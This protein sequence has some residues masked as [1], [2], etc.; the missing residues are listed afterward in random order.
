MRRSVRRQRGPRLPLPW[1]RRKPRVTPAVSPLRKPPLTHDR[2]GEWLY[3]LVLPKQ[4]E[5]VEAKFSVQVWS[6]EGVAL[7]GQGSFPQRLS[8]KRTLN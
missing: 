2:A 8:R 6:P 1:P 3:D 5:S 7:Q 4:L